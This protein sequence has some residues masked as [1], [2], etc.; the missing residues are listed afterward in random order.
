MVVYKSLKKQTNIKKDITT[1]SRNNTIS[2]DYPTPLNVTKTTTTCCRTSFVATTSKSIERHCYPTTTICYRAS[3]TTTAEAAANR[4]TRCQ[5]IVGCAPTT[6]SI[7]RH[8]YPTTNIW[9]HTTSIVAAAEAANRITCCQD[10]GG[11]KGKGGGALILSI[12][13]ILNLALTLTIPFPKRNVHH[14]KRMH[15]RK[16]ERKIMLG[17]R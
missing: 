16:R 14:P 11:G 1:D 15:Q 2:K 17:L 13:L 3:F 8:C 4:A 10:K 7:E 9:C 6:E 5:D 12:C